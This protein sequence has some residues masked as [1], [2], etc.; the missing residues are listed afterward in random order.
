MDTKPP[1]KYG[2]F[3]FFFLPNIK[4]DGEE[5]EK[6]AEEGRNKQ[7]KNKI[8]SLDFLNNSNIDNSVSGKVA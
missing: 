8:T 2:L 5:E 4:Q 1:I 7:K 6:Q 3:F